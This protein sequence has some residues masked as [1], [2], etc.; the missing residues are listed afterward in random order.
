M[1][2]V[3][4]FP[5]QLGVLKDTFEKVLHDTFQT[6]FQTFLIT[7]AD[8]FGVGYFVLFLLFLLRKLCTM[9]Q[10]HSKREIFNSH[11]VVFLSAPQPKMLSEL[12][13]KSN[14]TAIVLGDLSTSWPH[15][16]SMSSCLVKLFILF[17][18]LPNYFSCN[19]TL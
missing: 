1:L 19:F 15:S 9:L 3:L 8:F 17:G 4:L 5:F 10:F 13:P 18:F 6:V 16:H 11:G 14:Y 7:V 12:P 2:L